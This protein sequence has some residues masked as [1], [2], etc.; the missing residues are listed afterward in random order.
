MT[1]GAHPSHTKRMTTHVEETHKK[2]K[3]TK[4]PVITLTEDVVEFVEEKV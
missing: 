2:M 3:Y 1:S 4:D